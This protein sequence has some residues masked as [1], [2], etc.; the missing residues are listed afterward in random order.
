MLDLCFIGVSGALILPDPGNLE[1]WSTLERNKYLR[2]G[3]ETI[4][5]RDPVQLTRVCSRCHLTDSHP[6][7]SEA[8][9]KVPSHFFPLE[10]IK[11]AVVDLPPREGSLAPGEHKGIDSGQKT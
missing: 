3:P 10:R 2:H 8:C 11:S 5:I 4:N 6:L 7:D 1:C 9:Y